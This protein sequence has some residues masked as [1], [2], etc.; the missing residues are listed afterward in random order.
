M[1]EQ[2]GT[3]AHLI[4]WML[5][6]DLDEVLQL[7]P[8]VEVPDLPPQH[9]H[10]SN[11]KRC[12]HGCPT[13]SPSLI[14]A[15]FSVGPQQRA[16]CFGISWTRAGQVTAVEMVLFSRTEESMHLV[17]YEGKRPGHRRQQ[18]H[19]DADDPHCLCPKPVHATSRLPLPLASPFHQG[20]QAAQPRQI[21]L[22]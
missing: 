5:N 3:A 2:Q 20:G 10:A 15:P 11:L 12:P 22:F 7:R 17:E 1:A 19:A 16:A 9:L 21:L 8:C 4:L 14:R 18:H 13:V 6:M